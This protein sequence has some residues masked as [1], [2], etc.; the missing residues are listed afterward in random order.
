ML[1]DG[2]TAVVTGAGS[3]IGRAAALL[4]ASHGA[5]VVVADLN[6]EGGEATARE[7]QDSGGE[8]LFVQ[9]DVSARPDVERLIAKVQERYARLDVMVNAAGILDRMPVLEQRDD[10]WDR[11]FAVNV[12]GVYLCSQAA[13]R[14]MVRQG[15][16]SIVNVSSGGAFQ[17]LPELA[18]YAATK[19]AVIAFSKVLALEVGRG[20][21]VRVNVVAP[22]ATDTP[23]ARAGA[24]D[25][26]MAA[27]SRRFLYG[28]HLRPEEVAQAILF[29]ASDAG[30][31]I[32][33]QVIHVNGGTYMP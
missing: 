5:R 31:G 13:A 14:E 17:P 23:M 20:G 11:L 29:L 28:R 18:C 15:G 12:K 8:A 9:T 6:A 19:A 27:R 33:G 10:V 4:L 25:E 2:R 7:I 24:T 30:S 26:E 1:V 3:G 32:T 21:A 22:G 16:G